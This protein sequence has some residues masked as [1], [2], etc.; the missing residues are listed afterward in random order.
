MP[1]YFQFYQNFIDNKERLNIKKAVQ[2]LQKPHLII[3][4]QAD[5]TV[6]P[7][8]AQNIHS[9]NSKSELYLVKK[10]NHTFGSKHPWD[11]RELPNELRDAT[12]KTIAFIKAL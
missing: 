1:H 10:A 8:E 4:G 7:T 9:W 12:Q 6:K 2:N 11:S 3:H 5:D